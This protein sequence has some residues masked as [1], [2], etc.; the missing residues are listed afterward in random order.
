M[1]DL[2]VGL[3]GTIILLF[4]CYVLASSKYQRNWSKFTAP[5]YKKENF[6]PKTLQPFDEVL[7]WNGNDCVW[8]CD[9]FSYYKEDELHP[10]VCINSSYICVIPYN[11]KT[12]KFAGTSKIV[13][14]YYRYWED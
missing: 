10:C 13:P 6:N 3:C 14:E 11:N 9:F 7:C 12:K 1:I 8:E 5:W 4:I 2:I